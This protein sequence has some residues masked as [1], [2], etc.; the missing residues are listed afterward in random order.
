MILLDEKGHLVSTEGAEELHR[1]AR[2]IKL[3]RS[4]Y[5]DGKHPHYDLTTQ[6][7]YDRAVLRGAHQ[8][9]SKELAKRAWWAEPM[10]GMNNEDS[11]FRIVQMGRFGSD[12]IYTIDE[13]I[14]RRRK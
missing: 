14:M 3:R 6:R 1:F 9:H 8:V 7:K 10:S 12:G 5:Q 13:L 2:R 11:D 4:W